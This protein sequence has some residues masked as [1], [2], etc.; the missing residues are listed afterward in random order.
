MRK[1]KKNEHLMESELV[2]R[3]QN[4]DIDAFDELFSKYGNRLFAFA[5]SYLK[6]KEESEELVQDVFLKVWENRKGL[7][8]ESSFKSYLFTVA[9][10]NMCRLFR[11]KQIHQKFLDRGVIAENS[12]TSL[13]DQI[14]YR[15]ALEQIDELIR[16]LPEK[17]R[18][19]FIK[20]RREGKSTQEI[21]QE[22][23]L[24]PGTVDNQ[25]SAALKFLRKHISMSNFLLLMFFS[26]FIQ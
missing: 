16:K 21:A 26:I 5:L 24:A 23:N 13:E 25:I 22:M 1:V 11:K 4:G 8:K 6:S 9:Y 10:H 19:I 20:S 14:E 3:L 2:S 17:Q 18:V 12:T 7:R 15:I